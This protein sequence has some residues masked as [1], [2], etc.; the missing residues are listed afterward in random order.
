MRFAS[1]RVDVTLT[2]VLRLRS[3]IESLTGKRLLLGME[4]PSKK[5]LKLADNSHDGAK[6][7]AG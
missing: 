4:E 3:A 5:R 2:K 6:S 1:H 7:H